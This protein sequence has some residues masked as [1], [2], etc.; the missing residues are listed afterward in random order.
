MNI[1]TKS[2]QARQQHGVNSGSGTGLTSRCT[3]PTA[4]LVVTL[5]RKGSGLAEL[6]ISD[7]LP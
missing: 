1:L 5:N 2:D 4:K 3:S 6:I 7:D